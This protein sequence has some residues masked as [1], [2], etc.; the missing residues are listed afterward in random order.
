MSP[1]CLLA[2]FALVA[3]RSPRP[4]V[5]LPPTV[6]TVSVSDP[7]GAIARAPGAPDAAAPTVTTG[8][9]QP[10]AMALRIVAIAEGSED[11]EAA[12]DPARGLIVARFLEPPA[13][14]RGG[15]TIEHRRVCPAAMGGEIA[16]LRADQI[17]RAHV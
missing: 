9:A 8:A 7:E 13:S 1:R 5:S 17:G 16:G 3:C 10:S 2:L 14:G 11:L 12:I 15:E 4:A 6:A